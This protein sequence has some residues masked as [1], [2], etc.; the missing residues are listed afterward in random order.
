MTEGPVSQFHDHDPAPESEPDQERG[1]APAECRALL[2]QAAKIRVPSLRAP[3]GGPSLNARQKIDRLE[4]HLIAISRWRAVLEEAML[5]TQMATK[6]LEDEWDQIEGWETLRNGDTNKSI[7]EAKRKLRP[8]LYD[9][10]REGKWLADKLHRQIRRLERDEE[11]T[12][13]RAYTMLTGG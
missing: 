1:F 2:L 11:N 12:V 6:S 7:V 8:E 5:Y 9:G 10:I 13:S 4:D 3:A